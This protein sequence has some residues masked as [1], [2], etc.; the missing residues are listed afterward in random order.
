MQ[1]IML[2]P[3]GAGKGTQSKRLAQKLKVSHI[4]TGDLLRQNEKEQTSLGKDAKDFMNR[5][6]LVPD[7]LVAQMLQERFNATDI[8][9]GFILDGY[10]RNLNQA[11][12]LEVILEKKQISIDT[13]IYLD[14]SVP[15]II[16][17]LTGRRVCSGCQANYHIKNMPPKKDGY[18]DQCNQT[19]YQRTDDNEA[20]V[21]KRLDVYKKEVSTL[22]DYYKE[23]HLLVEFSADEDA[24]VVLQKIAEYL[25][26]NDSPKN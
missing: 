21:M 24:G 19:L 16:Q 17:R 25:S 4:S 15:V 10:P 11:K 3:P 1:I 7:E 2:G 12:T 5:G 22:I 20:T 14:T 18:C 13:V 26:G 8:K 9:N 23:K 6:L